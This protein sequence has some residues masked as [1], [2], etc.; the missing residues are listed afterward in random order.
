[1]EAHT[2]L[3]LF[4]GQLYVTLSLLQW[5][6]RNQ[7]FGPEAVAVLEGVPLLEEVHHSRSEL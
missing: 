4:Q 1:M 7:Q 5:L 3:A 2:L 6:C